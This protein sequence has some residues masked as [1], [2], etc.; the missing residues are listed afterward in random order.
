MV[1]QIAAHL[2]IETLGRLAVE[3]GQVGVQHHP[4]AA[5][6]VNALDSGALR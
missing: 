2:L 6:Q 5:H 4:L 3:G 1:N